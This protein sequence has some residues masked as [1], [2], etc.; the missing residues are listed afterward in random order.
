MPSARK[1]WQLRP[2]DPATS[3]R[4]A[5]AAK[6]SQVVAQLLLNRGVADAATARAFLDAPLSGL[7]APDL[8]PG[9]TEA[10][11]RIVRA[12]ADGRRVCVYGDY[13]VDGTTGTALLL[14]LLKLL[15][16]EPEFYV[17]NRLDEGYG[18]NLE[19][20]RQLAGSGVSLV[21][22]VDCGIT[23]VR[24]AEEANRLGL[25][26][27]VTDHHE[28]KD[29]LP[30]A[31]VLV[32]PRLSGSGYPHGGLCGAGVAFKLAW[33]IAKRASGGERVTPELRE[34]LLDGLGLT[35]LG[36]VADV[37]PLRDETR[38]LVRHGLERLARRPSVGL[39]A[40]IEAAKLGEGKPLKAEDIGFRLAPRLN[41]AGR[42]E[43][44]RLVIELLTT[45][46]PV[47]ARELAEYLE[48]LNQ[49]RQTIERKITA[50]AKDIVEAQGYD[51]A[52]G[53]VLGR[54]ESE[55]HPGVIGIVASRLAEQYARPVLIAALKDGDAPSPGSGR[56]VAGFALHEAL[57]ACSA[58]LVTHG[59]HAA[60]AGFRVR[61]S[62]LDALREL[63]V[64]VAEKR[65]AGEPPTPALVLDAEVPL[66]A[67]TFGLMD[68]L[69]KLEPYG[70][71]NPRPKFLASGLAVEGVPR[72]IGTGERHLSFRVRQGGTTVRAVAWGMGDRLDEL[73][74]AGGGC[75]L[76]FTP[77]VNEWNGYRSVE[78]QVDDL[79]PGAEP[80]LG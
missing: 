22:T 48:S 40:L 71:D 12:V 8:L 54:P 15:G 17:P 77:R 73:M 60:A 78:M 57:E 80:V 9:A 5:S 28:M 68:E 51:S 44:A 42:L 39:K 65:F 37:M 29:D 19:A 50:H 35:A 2:A 55:W 4:L 38:A 18:L 66:A 23:S 79:Q 67:L 52:A 33:E 7:H 61:P 11:E 58:E 13:D 3:G 70:A 62:R 26:L 36:A 10:A 43:C 45:T 76:A 49:Q 47:K 24:E 41:A 20:V 75:C 74:S 69:D 32:H 31:A 16:A 14:G 21:V 30:P 34:F 56:T 46:S 53:I 27:I 25:E 63:F 6:T 59:G 64:R 72:R 1:T